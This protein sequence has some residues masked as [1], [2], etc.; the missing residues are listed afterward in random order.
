[1]SVDDSSYTTGNSGDLDR[2]TAGRSLFDAEE[3]AIQRAETILADPEENTPRVIEE[4]SS[5]LAAYKKIYKQTRR[6]VRMSDLQQQKLNNAI[7]EIETARAMAEKANRAKSDFL[8]NMSHEI[9]T[10][11]NAVISMTDLAL[12]ND[13]PQQVRHY[14]NIVK[15]SANSLLGVINDILDFSKIE[16]GKLELEHAEFN[17]IDVLNGIADLLSEKASSK[18]IEM[19]LFIEPDVPTTLIGD[20]LRLGQ[21]LI[22][23]VNNAVKFTGKGEIV[24][25]VKRSTDSP[26]D[27]LRLLFSITDTGIGID[28][29]LLPKLFTSFMQADTSTTRKYG[30]SGL[31]LSICKLLVELMGGEIQAESIPGVG[32]TFSFSATFETRGIE[33]LPTLPDSL[34]GARVLV[35]EDN[36]TARRMLID[37]L[38]YMGLS[39]QSVSRC[40]ATY[41]F[42][43]GGDREASWDLLI[44]DWNTPGENGIEAVR[45]IRREP[46]CAELPIVLMVDF[47]VGDGYRRAVVAGADAVLVKPVKRNALYDTIL[48]VFGRQPT[49]AQEPEPTEETDNAERLRNI[50]LLLAE[51]NDINQQVM[52]EI[53]S[54]A[55]VELIIVEN[56]LEAVAAFRRE[57]FHAILMDVQM[58]EMDGFEATKRI[59]ALEKGKTV[60]I[61]AMTAHAL[62]DDREKCLAAGMND[63]VIKPIDTDILF[64]TLAKWVSPRQPNGSP[65]AAAETNGADT[66]PASDIN[67]E[68]GLKRLR[69]NRR[70][71]R[72]L[73]SDFGR[74]FG[75]SASYIRNA[76]SRGD[77]EAAISRL[78]TIKGVAGNLSATRLLEATKALEEV[79][80]KQKA[81]EHEDRIETF[82]WELNRVISAAGALLE[83]LP[84]PQVIS[85]SFAGRMRSLPG[86]VG[87]EDLAPL[88]FQ[89]N[90]Y[91]LRHN[92]LAE[93]CLE[94]LRSKLDTKDDDVTASLT[95]LGNRLNTYDFRGAQRYLE[96]FAKRFGIRLD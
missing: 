47:A 4:F 33:S 7:R 20:S 54:S 14:L 43:F 55:D 60:P 24:I 9:R 17:L 46:A 39:T 31:G 61:I 93:K 6:L 56:G 30:G 85:D 44:L 80:R 45:R 73:L 50:K 65:P 19:V 91:L 3:K 2:E 27:R 15:T 25:R 66:S 58:P 67:V 78:H 63:Y 41:R 83:A 10:P 29:A 92:P 1:M 68:A 5:L 95:E 69:G 21:V 90:E 84:A 40:D 82:E 88:F 12:G 94:H 71:F 36:P 34:T 48:E 62:K 96:V 38:T 26:D 57:H 8:A 64:E 72:K 70:L 76:V 23:L 87:P 49:A 42:L 81:G 59:R 75:D 28:P 77:I 53:F 86:G 35:A 32:S 74:E 37:A 11:M 79:L 52:M 16:A 51:D 89:L 18:G 13:L 22:N